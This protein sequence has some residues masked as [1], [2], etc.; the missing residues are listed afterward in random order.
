MSS[1]VEPIKRRR[2]CYSRNLFGA[3]YSEF[4]RLA[5]ASMGSWAGSRVHRGDS[6]GRPAGAMQAA[7]RHIGFINGFGKRSWRVGG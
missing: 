1:P 2:E 5:S 4:H 6:G 7:A 3:L